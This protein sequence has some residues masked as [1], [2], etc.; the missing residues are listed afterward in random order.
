[1][2]LEQYIDEW[3]QQ[4][5]NY[6]LS[7]VAYKTALLTHFSKEVAQWHEKHEEGLEFGDCSISLSSSNR[8][9]Q[10]WFMQCFG[11]V[12]ADLGKKWEKLLEEYDKTKMKYEKT[13]PHPLREGWELII[14]AR[15]CAPPP[16]CKVV[17]VEETVPEHKRMVKK[18]EC[19]KQEEE[20]TPEQELEELEEIKI[21][22]NAE[23]DQEMLD[24]NDRIG[25]EG[26]PK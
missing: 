6:E 1:M 12:G 17:E 8:E 11:A 15:N 25:E 18:I 5:I 7:R 14:S 9:K 13:I 4:S 3:S 10:L 23:P 26:L 16:S 22:A 24:N 2:K 20:L 21:Q 19:P